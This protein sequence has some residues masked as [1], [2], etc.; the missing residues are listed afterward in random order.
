MDHYQLIAALHDTFSSL[1][2]RLAE[3]RLNLAQFPLLNARVF[4]LPTV[5]KGKEH[6]P[7]TQITVT[8]LLG[9]A[10][11]DA[12]LAHFQRL[13][14]HHY[15]ETVSSKAAIRLP[16]ALCFEVT[17]EE[18]EQTRQLTETINALKA[19]LEQ[20]ITRESGLAAEQR[21]EFVHAHLPGLIT[22][23]AY[24]SLTLLTDPD[25]VRFGWANKH[26]VNTLTREAVLAKLEKSFQA[27]RGISATEKA[28]WQARVTQEIIDVK[29][30]PQD[31]VLKIKRPVKVQPIARV[32]YQDA[33]KQVQHPCPSPLLVLCRDPSRAPLIGELGNYLADSTQPKFT[34]KAKPLRLLIPRLHLYLDESAHG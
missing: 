8:I 34:P 14:I 11:R 19:T 27:E 21:F 15:A 1:E 7:I 18:Y 5:E 12:G 16:G 6:D 30:L 25:T 17:Q 32:W 4:P 23:S 9:D 29:R 24:R 2:K 28:T 31:A 20:L 26:V 22:L 13:F 10:A 3:L 33:Q